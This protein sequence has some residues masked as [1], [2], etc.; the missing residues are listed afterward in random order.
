MF[1]RAYILA[2][3]LCVG[4]PLTA[5]PQ[6]IDEISQKAN[7]AYVAQDWQKA[8]AL[9]AQITE[10]QETNGQAWYRL[11]M[12][13][14]SIGKL[15]EAKKSMASAAANGVPANYTNFEIAKIEALNGNMDESVHLLEQL[16]AGGF[17]NLQA[18]EGATEFAALTGNDR[19]KAALAQVRRNAQPCEE[20]GYRDFDFWLGHWD[21]TDQSGTPQGANRITREESGCVLVEKWTSVQGGSGMSMNYYDAGTN[22]WWQHWV[23][24]GLLID[25]EGGVKDG[26]MHLLGTAYYMTNGNRN[27]FRGTWTPLP[28][29]RVRQFFEQSTDGGETWNV[30]FDGYYA[31]QSDD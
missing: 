20:G 5:L 30:W 6:D 12:S 13:Q 16:A 24:S 29:G 18:L 11:G 1:A 7:D 22:T 9:Y 3:V 31:K 17:S 10:T 15:D 2:V 14:K 4:T 25:I 28:D 23:S 21:V 8:T 26:A 19:Y 27:P